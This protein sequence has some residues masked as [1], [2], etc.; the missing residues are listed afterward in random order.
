MKQIVQN[1]GSGELLMVEVPDPADKKNMVRVENVAS[2]VSLGT[3]KSIID[4]AQKSLVGKALARPDWVKQ[5]ID[6]IKTEGLKEAWRQS[7]ARLDLPVPLGYSSAG[8]VT[9]V[10]VNDFNIGERIACTGAGYASHAETVL[11]PPNLCARIPDN[12][13]FEEASYAALGGIAMEAVRLAKVEF[14][15]KVALIG[16]GLLGQLALQILN[17]AG[18]H[19]LG[20]DI[21]KEKCELAETH[22]IRKAIIAGQ[23]N[24]VE[25]AME[26]TAGEG[27]DSV[28]IFASSSSNQ[29]IEQAAAI[30]RERGRIVAGGLIGLNIPRNLFFEKEL[31]FCVSRAWGPGALNS[32]YEERNIKWPYA[33]ARWTAQQNLMEF[34]NMISVGRI[35]LDHL[36]TH[37]FPFNDALQAYEMLLSGKEPAIGVVLEYPRKRASENPPVDVIY[38]NRDS[39]PGTGEKSVGIGFI[40]AGL[41][42]RGT[43][44][45]AMKKMDDIRFVGVSSAKGLNA[46]N[47]MEQVGF[48]Y[49]TSDYR[50]L[51]NDPD[52]DI[53]FVLTRHNSHAFFLC[54]A[55]EH[56]KH[57]FV[58]KPLCIDLEQLKKIV[59]V[60]AR[61]RQSTP[62]PIVMTGF[63]RRFSPAALTAGE[64]LGSDAGD[65]VIQMRC[66]AGAIP[67]D[68]WVH[69]PEEG[70]GRIIG[71][72]C[73]FVD[74]AQYLTSSTPRSVFAACTE[75]GAN[76]RDNLCITLKMENGAPVTI[77]YASN[78][79]KSF[80]REEVQI[81]S[82]GSVFVI[83]NFKNTIHVSNGKTRK[84]RAM[85]VDRGHK[86]QIVQTIDAIKTGKP[87]PIEMASLIATTLTTFAIETSLRTG[88]SVNIDFNSV[89]Q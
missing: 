66:N 15:H 61:S 32:D 22:G 48:S 11:V 28:I 81:F 38:R 86:A 89:S 77:T 79:D 63:N 82:K 53:V 4:V 75:G 74:L 73:H 87:S 69:H 2:L 37:R 29:P 19:V 20:V 7:K 14:G 70:G 31:E 39:H 58:E 45:P 3:E 85:E 1:Y 5:V 18:C 64:F 44:A 84:K 49:C 47:L 34:L 25:A 88:Q 41:F 65:C 21:S 59:D 72:V 71:E 35:R 40:G 56:G 76:T 57:V 55:L 10:S 68:S 13:S 23:N 8:V 33:Y 27:M 80:S 16:L 52:I 51:L 67:K 50:K 36:T 43:L 12:V 83:D 78:G 54:E 17:A 42:T 24:L 26:F 46:Q 62:A 60:Y 30:G 9:K 6:K